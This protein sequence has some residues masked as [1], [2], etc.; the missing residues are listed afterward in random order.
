MPLLCWSVAVSTYTK[1]FK[2]IHSVQRP[3]WGE[4]LFA[5]SVG[6][7]AYVARSHWVYSA[8][9]LIMSVADG[10]AAVIGMK[11]GR[12]NRYS[13]FGYTKSVAGTI[14]FLVATIIILLGFSQAMPGIFSYWFVAIALLA[15]ILENVSIRGLD[16]LLVPVVVAICL[17]A[18]H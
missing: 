17:N 4:L 12:S 8:A 7:L 18:V 5:A 11:F 16:N 9:L 6:V 15:T 2:A 1:F 14:T 13:V 3:T 10:L